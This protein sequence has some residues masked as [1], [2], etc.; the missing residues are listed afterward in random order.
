MRWATCAVA[1]MVAVSVLGCNRGTKTQ[2]TRSQL[3]ERA[4]HVTAYRAQVTSHYKVGGHEVSITGNV[5]AQPPDNLRVEMFAPDGTL[6]RV[7][8]QHGD[9]MMQHD[10]THQRVTKVDLARVAKATGKR[11]PGAQ[12]TD[13]SHPFEGLDPAATTFVDRV[14]LPEG[15]ADLFEGPLLN[16]DSIAARLGFHPTKARV[17]VDDQTGLLRRTEIVGEKDDEGLIQ[18]FTAVEVDPALEPEIF[19]LN[20]P[21]GVEVADL[22]DAMIEALS[23]Q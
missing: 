1:V 4:S 3:E 12:G 2:V 13:L 7:M 22:T 10:P 9:V 14:D 20:P 21:A 6:A 11:P 8:V 18:E 23:K 19:L 17:W 5:Q 16:A 15:K